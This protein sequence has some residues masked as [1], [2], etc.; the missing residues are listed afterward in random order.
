MKNPGVTT[1]LESYRQT[2]DNLDAALV[3]ILAERFRCTNEVGILKAEHTLPSTDRGREERQFARLRELAV[4]S[5]IDPHVIEEILRYI[6]G[7][8]VKRH[9]QIAH[10]YSTAGS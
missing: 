3:H 6:I 7:E 1:R 8:V 9:D 5:Q 4:D 10:E 2:I